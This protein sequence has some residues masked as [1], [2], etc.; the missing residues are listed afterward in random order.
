MTALIALFREPRPTR[1]S[2]SE[3]LGDPLC[4]GASISPTQ[5]GRLSFDFQCRFC[6]FFC[7]S[8][9]YPSP[10]FLWFISFLC[11]LSFFFHF[12]I[13]PSYFQF[14]I[15]FLLNGGRHQPRLLWVP[16]TLGQA[17]IKSILC[18]LPYISLY[19]A[20][21]V[22]LLFSSYLIAS[23]DFKLLCFFCFFYLS[24]THEK[25]GLSVALTQKCSLSTF[26]WDLFCPSGTLEIL[27]AL[28]SIFSAKE[29]VAP[30]LSCFFFLLSKEKTR[31]AFFIFFIL[32]ALYV[33]SCGILLLFEISYLFFSLFFL[34]IFGL[35]PG[36]SIFRDKTLHEVQTNSP[37]VF[38]DQGIFRPYY[39]ITYFLWY[40][41]EKK[42]FFCGSLDYSLVRSQ[43]SHCIT[44]SRPF[45]SLRREN[46]P[47]LLILP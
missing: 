23:L 21:L 1:L 36:E 41:K 13:F 47:L 2:K 5:S 39:V 25:I 8:Q 37:Y 29:P 14:L 44:L 16:S 6:L 26:S 19:N 11:F 32:S 17:L 43:L 33:P 42:I 31:G 18:F 45:A 46:E 3:L 15:I 9:I 40:R 22:S 30:C 38:F 28:P 20:F 34:L 35:L 12:C 27:R 10:F 24:L 7:L 4:V